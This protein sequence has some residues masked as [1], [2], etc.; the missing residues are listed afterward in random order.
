MKLWDV[1]G[2]PV[3]AEFDCTSCNADTKLWVGSVCFEKQ[4]CP[5]CYDELKICKEI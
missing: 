5:F 3:K 2:E 1:D 4:L